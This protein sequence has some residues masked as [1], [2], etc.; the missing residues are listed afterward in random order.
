MVE[1]DGLR[2]ISVQAQQADL[3][4]SISPYSKL[5]ASS[6][7]PVL[8]TATQ[9]PREGEEKKLENETEGS[10]KHKIMK[11]EN[12]SI[13]ERER[14]YGTRILSTSEIVPK[15]MKFGEKLLDIANKTDSN[16]IYIRNHLLTSTPTIVYLPTWSNEL[17]TSMISVTD[18]SVV[19]ERLEEIFEMNRTQEESINISENDKRKE[20]ISSDLTINSMDTNSYT[21]SDEE[22]KVVLTKSRSTIKAS[23]EIDQEIV[24]SSTNEYIPDGKRITTE[25]DWNETMAEVIPFKSKTLIPLQQLISTVVPSVKSS[26][27]ET[28]VQKRKEEISTN[29]NGTSI[30]EVKQEWREAMKLLEVFRKQL[31]TFEENMKQMMHKK[32]AIDE[33]R[34]KN[35]RNRKANNTNISG[36][37]RRRNGQQRPVQFENKEKKAEKLLS[38]NWDFNDSTESIDIGKQ[39]DFK[40][41]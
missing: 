20:T 16:D 18:V 32:N 5:S 33:K 25:T 24:A 37:G 1:E 35:R 4:Q 38:A 8:I 10:L 6:S 9:V 2:S 26:T 23:G 11:T 41:Y 15:K 3:G 21:P 36:S 29:V 17:Q 13:V 34:R 39:N 31:Q 22:T 30:E 19:N 12:S 40:C 27:S 14:R 7:I 28:T